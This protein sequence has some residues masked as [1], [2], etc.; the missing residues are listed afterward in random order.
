NLYPKADAH[1]QGE[2]YV[3]SFSEGGELHPF[4]HACAPDV[5][6]QHLNRAGFEERPQLPA[7]AIALAN[8][9]RRRHTGGKPRVSWHIFRREWRFKPGRPARVQLA[10][11]PR[12]FGG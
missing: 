11:E 8:G 9:N 3:I 2:R 6:L 4:G 10:P 5:R 12:G 7:R 1:V